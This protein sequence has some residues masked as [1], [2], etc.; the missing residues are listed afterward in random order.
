MSAILLVAP[1][2]EPLSLAEAKAFLRVEHDD[3]DS[4]VTAADHCRT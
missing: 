2:V 4:L 3:D 1:S